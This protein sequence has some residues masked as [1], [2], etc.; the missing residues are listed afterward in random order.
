MQQK[1]LHKIFSAGFCFITLA[2]S[3]QH[4]NSRGASEV[5]K[6]TVLSRLATS[7]IDTV[8]T[9]KVL[10]V[11]FETKMVMSEIGK[12]VNA[13]THLS[14]N[15]ITEEFRKEMDLA[16][17]AAIKKNCTT[18]SLLD[19][20]PKSDSTLAYIYG[21]T[22]YSYDIV[23]GTVPES[24]SKDNKNNGNYI[25]NGQ[26]EVP[27]DYSQRFMN[28]S[29]LNPKLLPDL[30]T[31]YNT[32]TY[33]FLNELDIK[34]VENNANNLSD[35]AY[36][37]EVTVHYSIVDNTGHY[38]S[39]GIATT[40]FPYHENDPKV[41]GEKYFPALAKTIEKDYIKGLLSDKMQADQKTQQS[42]NKGLFK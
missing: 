10:I 14:Y 39:K 7:K 29:F 31:K 13:K 19:G 20:K 28:I 9:H 21:S 4:I 17:F 40:Y 27:V 32:D 38:V 5:P 6:D 34:N 24:G 25:K 37:R 12:E 26:L 35:D 41:I 11:P 30:G 3:A 22:S 42:Q 1:K 8:L 33:I 16:M 23:P 2:V 15:A 36:R 18:V